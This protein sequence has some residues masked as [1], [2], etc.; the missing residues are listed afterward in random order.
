MPL[1]WACR[2]NSLYIGG[3][4]F[5]WHPSIHFEISQHASKRIKM[6]MF[7]ILCQFYTSISRCLWSLNLKYRGPRCKLMLF[8]SRQSLP[9]SLKQK[10]NPADLL[11]LSR[12]IF[13][14]FEVRCAKNNKQYRHLILHYDIFNYSPSRSKN[15]LYEITKLWRKTALI[16]FVLRTEAIWFDFHLKVLVSPRN[17]NGQGSS[18]SLT[19]TSN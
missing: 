13:F 11:H 6:F 19:I 8:T 16:T 4:C 2:I 9:M 14:F 5:T 1:C 18:S 3:G 12:W 17:I 10:Q 15:T 7:T